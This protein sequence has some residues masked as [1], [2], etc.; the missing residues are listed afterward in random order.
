MFFAMILSMT[1]PTAIFL[2]EVRNATEA[3]IALMRGSPCVPRTLQM[4]KSW[5]GFEPR[6]FG[7]EAE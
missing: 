4:S 6:T 7:T 5:A 2:K 1:F 3:H